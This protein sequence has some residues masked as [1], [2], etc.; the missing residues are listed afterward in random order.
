MILAILFLVVLDIS[1][2]LSSLYEKLFMLIDLLAK[3]SAHGLTW[4]SLNSI[5][6]PKLICFIPVLVFS[7]MGRWAGPKPLFIIVV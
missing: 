4:A 3:S 6:G 1:S 2:G 5:N 7:K